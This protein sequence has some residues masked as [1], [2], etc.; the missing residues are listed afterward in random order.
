MSL[1]IKRVTRI[2]TLTTDAFWG[3]AL[4]KN[5]YLVDVRPE[6][7]QDGM[8]RYTLLLRDLLHDFVIGKGRT[9]GPKWGVSCDGNPLRLGEFHKLSLRTRRVKF[10]LIDRRDDGCVFQESLEITRTPVGDPNSSDFVGV[11]LVNLLDLLVDVQPVDPPVGLFILQDL[12]SDICS[13]RYTPAHPT[14]FGQGSRPVQQ[15]YTALD[16]TLQPDRWSTE[17]AQRSR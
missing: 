13:S 15:P 1:P 2:Q 3:H 16:L 10:D 4:G 17:H 5:T 14:Y 7:D 6:T 9:G 8:G 12:T 11:L